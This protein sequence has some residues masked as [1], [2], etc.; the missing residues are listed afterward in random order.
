MHSSLH[1]T[2]RRHQITSGSVATRGGHNRTGHNRTGRFRLNR[3][4]GFW[5]GAALLA[6]TGCLIGATFPCHYAAGLAM[7]ML[8][9]GIYFG[10]PGACVGALLGLLDERPPAAPVPTDDAELPR[11]VA[12]TGTARVAGAADATT[13][14][15]VHTSLTADGLIIRIE[16]V[17]SVNQAGP[18]LYGLLSAAARRPPVVTLDL[19]ELHFLSSLALGVLV[20]Y[21]GSVV[22]GGGQI[23][24]AEELQPAV[25]AALA[26]AGVLELFATPVATEAA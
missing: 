26:E 20:T 17:A 22:R 16:G 19:S 25:H 13:R 12:R 3:T 9:W 14:L 1:T 7:S 8:W 18:L 10:A 2:N 5:I 11:P 23:R 15:A 4:R 24:L 21:R 6:T